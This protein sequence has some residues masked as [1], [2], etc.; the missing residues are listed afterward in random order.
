MDKKEGV[1]YRTGIPKIVDI[2]EIVLALEAAGRV[3][4]FGSKSWSHE[5]VSE[6]TFAQAVI[7]DIQVAE[8]WRRSP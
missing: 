5:D 2:G 4:D 7:H 6:L 1:L 8:K 3:F